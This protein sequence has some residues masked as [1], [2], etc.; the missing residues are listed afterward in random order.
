MG[1]SSKRFAELERTWCSPQSQK[2]PQKR[3]NT[4]GESARCTKQWQKEAEGRKNLREMQ[5]IKK[6]PDNLPFRVDGSRGILVGAQR[7]S[8]RGGT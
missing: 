4:K 3:T 6:C 2:S 1:S 5:Q 8:G 7:G